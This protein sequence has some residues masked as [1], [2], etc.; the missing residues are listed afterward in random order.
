MHD[1]VCSMNLSR[2]LL[3]IT[4]QSRRRSLTFLIGVYVCTNIQNLNG[5]EGRRRGGSR[6]KYVRVEQLFSYASRYIELGAKLYNTK[7]TVALC[8]DSIYNGKYVDACGRT[9]PHRRRYFFFPLLKS[10]RHQ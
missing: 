4:T 9:S 5:L 10:R 2:L 7:F 3:G 1:N 8:P 6:W